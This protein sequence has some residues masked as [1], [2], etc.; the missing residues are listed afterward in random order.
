MHSDITGLYGQE[1]LQDGITR[2]YEL[3]RL[4][5]SAVEKEP[6][7]LLEWEG[8]KAFRELVLYLNPDLSREIPSSIQCSLDS[9]HFFTPR[10]GMPPELVKDFRIEVRRDGKWSVAGRTC[11]NYQRRASFTFSA[12]VSG[13]AVKVIIESTYGSPRAEVF[14]IEI[15]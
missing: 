4:W 2:P 5:S 9:H 1:N 13:D 12:A 10:P 11:G 7:I 3:P 8:T 14:E 6:S 15:Y